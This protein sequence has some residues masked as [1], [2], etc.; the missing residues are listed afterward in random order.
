MEGGRGFPLAHFTIVLKIDSKFLGVNMLL[1][2]F[3]LQERKYFSKNI[4]RAIKMCSL[5][6]IR[7]G[8]SKVVFPG[9]GGG[10]N[11]TAPSYFKKNLSNFNITL[12]NC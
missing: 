10:V 7:L 8:F 1:Q 12:Y 3:I 2:G 4:E 9:G 11:L 6:L 5:T